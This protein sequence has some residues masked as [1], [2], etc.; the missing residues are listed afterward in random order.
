LAEASIKAEVKLTFDKLKTIIAN[1]KDKIVYEDPPHS[2]TLVQGSIWGIT[3]RTAKK[4]TTYTLS[5]EAQETRITS[6]THLTSDYVNLALAGCIFS[7]ALL[8]VCIWI[9]LDLQNLAANK[10]IF[11][12]WLALT[13]GQVDSNK[14]NVFLWLTWFLSVFLAA[15]LALEAFIISKIRSGI[16]VFTQETLKALKE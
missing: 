3:P 11:W 1:E 9:A 16:G 12:S 8:I 14:A 5:Q 6:K 13:S 10:T 4:I 2:L 7:I 15:S